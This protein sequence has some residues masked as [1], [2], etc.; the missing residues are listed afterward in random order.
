MHQALTSVEKE[1]F[2]WYFAKETIRKIRKDGIVKYNKKAYQ[3]KK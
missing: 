3:I 1:R 2:E